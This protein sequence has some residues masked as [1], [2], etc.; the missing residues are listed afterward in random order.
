LVQRE[1]QPAATST[2]EASMEIDNGRRKK[3]EEIR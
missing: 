3:E 1:E 2:L